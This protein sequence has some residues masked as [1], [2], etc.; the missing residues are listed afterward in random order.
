MIEISIASRE[1]E[2]GDG[3]GIVELQ[4]TTLAGNDCFCEHDQAGKPAVQGDIEKDAQMALIR[5]DE[6][7]IVRAYHVVSGSY[8]KF[9]DIKL[10]QVQG[11]LPVISFAG[12]FVEINGDYIIVFERAIANAPNVILNGNRVAVEIRGGKARYNLVDFD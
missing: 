8:L 10:V 12:D 11:L 1:A 2:N 6:D 5:T 7:G 4:I 3:R 9:G